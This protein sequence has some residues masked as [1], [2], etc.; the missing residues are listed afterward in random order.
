VHAA[1]RA[2]GRRRWLATAV[3]ALA[4]LGLAVGA[5]GF[6]R[7]AERSEQA[8][9]LAECALADEQSE[10]KRWRGVAAE[11]DKELEQSRRRVAELLAAASAADASAA[12]L[13][14]G[15]KGGSSR[16]TVG[17][18]YPTPTVSVGRTLAAT[19]P[20]DRFDPLCG[21]KP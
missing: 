21:F 7:R 9:K 6:F 14:S 12:A 8:R 4:T 3:L 1:E 11:K 16:G 20:C 15:T 18:T 19:A 2:G 10:T 17:T 5:G 13:A